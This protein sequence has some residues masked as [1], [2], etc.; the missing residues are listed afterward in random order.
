MGELG[1]GIVSTR[2][3][4]TLHSSQDSGDLQ[5]RL[6]T[7]EREGDNKQSLC[8]GESD[9]GLEGTFCIGESGE[10]IIPSRRL[11]SLDAARTSGDHERRRLLTEERD[12]DNER[13]LRRGRSDGKLGGAF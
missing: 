1:D 13:S 5:S 2:T 7:G 3:I 8:K 4:I 9:G 12:G 10:G 6:L 11:S